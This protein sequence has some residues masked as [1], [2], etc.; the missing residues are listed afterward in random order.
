MQTYPACGRIVIQKSSLHGEKMENQSD[1]QNNKTTADALN[2]LA[3]FFLRQ[4]V[5][6]GISAIFSSYFWGELFVGSRS[7]IGVSLPELSYFDAVKLHFLFSFLLPF[8]QKN[9]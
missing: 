5:L 6:V 1:N 3:I 7:I 8:P 4:F 9:S 2:E